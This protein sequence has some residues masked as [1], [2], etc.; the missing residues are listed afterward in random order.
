MSFLRMSDASISGTIMWTVFG[1][2]GCALPAAEESA[3][4]NLTMP[5][6]R[7]GPHVQP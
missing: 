7:Q 3:K 1:C 6:E 5:G 2:R 4:V